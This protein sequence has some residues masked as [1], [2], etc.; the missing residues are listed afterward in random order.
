MIERIIDMSTLSKKKVPSKLQGPKYTPPKSYVLFGDKTTF[1]TGTK[2][3]V[4]IYHCW[5]Q[6]NLE[7]RI[8]QEQREPTR[9]ENSRLGFI[10][11]LNEN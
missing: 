2:A 4:N 3:A 9:I 1:I 5:P 7:K 10:E 8:I 6:Y 11:P